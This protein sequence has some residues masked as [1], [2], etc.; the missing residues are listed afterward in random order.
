MVFKFLTSRS[1]A[2]FVEE[3]PL[4]LILV[5]MSFGGSASRALPSALVDAVGR[6]EVGD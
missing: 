1:R 6:G 3:G 5:G 4:V 2:S